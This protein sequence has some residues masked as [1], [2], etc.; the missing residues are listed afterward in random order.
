MKAILFL[1]I[2]I[3]SNLYA[4]D[5]M[6]EAM[7]HINYVKE[8]NDRSHFYV[9]AGSFDQPVN[10]RHTKVHFIVTDSMGRRTGFESFFVTKRGSLLVN[11]YREIPNS[12]YGVDQIGSLDPSVV[13]DEPESAVL[14]FFPTVLKDTY[15]I[16]FIGFGDCKYSVGMYLRG[17]NGET[18]DSIRYKA[19]ITSGTTQQYSIYLDPAPGAPAPVITKTVTFEVLR[20]D[21]LVAQKLNQLGDDK[22]VNSLIKNI[23]LAEKLSAVCNKRKSKKEKCEPAIA[24]LRLVVKRLEKANQKCDSK[25]PKSC[26]EDKDWNNFDKAYR[27]DHDYDDFFKDWDRDDWHKWKK[28]CKRFV[29][30]EALKIIKEDAQWLIK[31]LGGEIEKEHGKE[32]S[33]D[34]DKPKQH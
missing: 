17:L 29:N 13:P 19:Y 4:E 33:K 30:D 26:D 2:F 3:G 23:N 18:G 16:Q 5:L 7:G 20:N 10:D 8:H 31:S 32:D 15:T 1:S 27:K 22:F 14:D 28:K 34:N 11:E 12:S 25:D 24:V 9:S 6:Q 21:I